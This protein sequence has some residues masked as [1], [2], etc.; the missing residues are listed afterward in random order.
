MPVKPMRPCNHP[1]C[2]ELVRDGRYCTNHERKQQQ[3]Y[4]NS[5]GSSNSR[6]YDGRWRKVRDIKLK[7]SPLCERCRNQ[8]RTVPATMV[9]HIVAI[10][11][12]GAAYNLE[13]LMSVCVRCHDEIHMEQGDKW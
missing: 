5:R 4:D 12:G 8:G 3:K 2:P 9:H 10:K 7:R 13:N 1:G 6:G 11:K